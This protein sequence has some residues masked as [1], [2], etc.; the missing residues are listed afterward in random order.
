L[1]LAV[2]IGHLRGAP[3]VVYE[4]TSQQTCCWQMPSSYAIWRWVWAPITSAA[5]RSRCVSHA[6]A[7]EAGLPEFETN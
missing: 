7:T 5:T 6:A 3:A 4:A 2:A 1:A